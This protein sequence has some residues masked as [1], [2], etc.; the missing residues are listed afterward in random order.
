MPRIVIENGPDRGESYVIQ[1]G[2]ELVAGRDPAAQIPIRD[3]MA[4]RRHF[5]I[6]HSDGRFQLRDLGSKNGLS[7]NGSRLEKTTTLSANDRIQV[8]ETLLTFVGDDPHPLLGREL[9]GYRIEDRVGRGGMGTVYRALQLSLDRTVALKILAPHLVENQSFI[10]LFIR[11]ARAAG[12]LSHPN[13]VQ[14]YD[15][16]V[17]EKIYFYSMEYIPYGSVEELLN[18]EKRLQLPRALEIVRDAALG[19]QY[20]ELKGLVHRDIKPGNLMIGTDNIIKIGDLGIARFGEE[21]GVVSQKDGVSGSPHYIA[22]EQARG[23]DIDHRADLYALG[24]SFYQMLCGETPY[25]GSTPREVILGHIK[26][27]PP[28]LSERAPEVPAPVIELVESMMEKDR[29][30]RVPS[31]TVI[32]ERLEPLMRRYRGDGDSSALPGGN[33]KAPYKWIA[34]LLVLGLVTIGITLGVLHRNNSVADERQK[35]ETWTGLVVD[36]ENFR[37]EDNAVAVSRALEHLIEIS[38][39]PPELVE[40]RAALETW[41]I[42]RQERQESE[43]RARFVAEAYETLLDHVK[44]LDNASALV[45]LDEFIAEHPE[46]E[47]AEEAKQRRDAIAEAMRLAADSE[48]TAKLRIQPLIKVAR[49]LAENGD[50]RRAL[51]RLASIS[52]PGTQAEAD[53]LAEVLRINQMARTAWDLHAGEVRRDIAEKLFNQARRTLLRFKTPESLELQV[54]DLEREIDAAEALEAEDSGEVPTT[55]PL[56]E[57]LR[58]ALREWAAGGS[59]RDLERPLRDH[60]FKDRLNPNERIILSQALD[61]MG[62]LPEFL[63]SVGQDLEPANPKVELSFVKGETK[64]FRL[65]DFNAKRIIG[66]EPGARAGTVI[67]WQELTPASRLLVLRTSS[68]LKPEQF[69]IYGWLAFANG[70]RTLA[71]QIWASAPAASA[72][73]IAG[74]R[75]LADRAEATND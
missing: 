74:L 33:S 58:T 54:A 67:Q 36:A 51:D 70:E 73:L 72:E 21:E 27:N 13:L 39:L 75:T 37:D 6:E 25:R 61:L 17:E 31:A 35:I 34:G 56:G 48:L 59:V 60:E 57:P 9:S 18:A 4:S 66:T 63:N 69:P 38:E 62:E 8:G 53:R 55:D 50:Y 20:A 65:S 64:K 14:V 7:L 45:A 16:G 49:D 29:E 22:P 40:R 32:L 30:Q 3:E 41:R 1:P 19:L 24:V 46:T 12:A 28:P 11:E 47:P 10:N 26:R 44:T 2:G 68:G 23:Q 71:N 15:V 42:D 5:Q 43:A 52:V